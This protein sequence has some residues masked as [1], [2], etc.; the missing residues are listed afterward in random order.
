MLANKNPPF[1]QQSL[2]QALE[3]DKKKK[4]QQGFSEYIDE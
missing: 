3:A 1:Q 4:Q 2:Q